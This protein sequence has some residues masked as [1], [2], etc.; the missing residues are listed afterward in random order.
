MKTILGILIAI[1]LVIG[2]YL[3]FANRTDDVNTNNNVATTTTD[4]VDNSTTSSDTTNSTTTN[5]NNNS[6]STGTVVSTADIRITSPKSGSTVSS[7]LKVTGEAKGNWFF[8]ASAP[9]YLEDA[10]G[11]KIAQGIITATGDWMT[12]NFVPFTGTL[13]WSATSTTSTSTKANL[14]FMNDNP[15]GLPSLSKKVVVPVVLSR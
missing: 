11:K 2:G 12:T 1:A 7:P 14:V 13:T 4:V 6:N 3:L 5:T 8:E 10:N 9:V 15:S